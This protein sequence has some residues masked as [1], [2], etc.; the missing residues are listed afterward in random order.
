MASSDA[1]SKNSDS[2]SVRTTPAWWNSASTV[3]S[4]APTRAPVCER[5]ARA[6]AADRPLLTAM[7]GFV[8]PTRRA[9]RENLRGL[10]TDSRYSAMT[11]HAGS[12]SQYW[13][14]SLPERS[15]LLPIEM[16]R[17]QPEAQA[18]GV[19]DDREAERAALATGTRPAR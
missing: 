15:A 10:P 1:T 3:T 18:V 8:R 17:G 5:L 14:K 11:L 13:R 4:D 2:V 16:K 19:L 12:A 7:I 9:I 6:P